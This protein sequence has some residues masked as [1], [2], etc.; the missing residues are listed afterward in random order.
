MATGSE[1]DQAHFHKTSSLVWRIKTLE[2]LHSILSICDTCLSNGNLAETGFQHWHL[3]QFVPV[4][5]WRRWRL[6]LQQDEE[7]HYC[8][9]LLHAYPYQLLSK[10]KLRLFYCDRSHSA[11]RST[12]V[13][14]LAKYSSELLV[15]CEVMAWQIRH[16][17]IRKAH[18]GS[19]TPP[20]ILN[21]LSS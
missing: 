6:R 13:R 5:A 19:W 4:K 14:L 12:S 8:G 15:T 2:N 7:S 21:T 11:V 9:C 10:K 3:P 1:I 17:Q 18:V 16:G 20:P